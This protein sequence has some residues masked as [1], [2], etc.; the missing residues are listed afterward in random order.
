MELIKLNAC[1]LLAGW[2]IHWLRFNL[3]NEVCFVDWNEFTAPKHSSFQFNQTSNQMTAI[4]NFR[5]HQFYSFFSQLFNYI[6]FRIHKIYCYNNMF[7]L[8]GCIHQAIHSVPFNQLN[9]LIKWINVLIQFGLM[10]VDLNWELNW[11]LDWML[12]P[13]M[14]EIVVV[15]E[16]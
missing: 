13:V 10:I 8:T 15:A 9:Q 14:E 12:Q 16:I 5:L 11:M 6:A 7:M 1:L 4:M 3:I 2:V